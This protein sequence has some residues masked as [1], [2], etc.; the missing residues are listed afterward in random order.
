MAGSGT[1][2]GGAG[3]RDGYR[4]ATQRWLPGLSGHKKSKLKQELEAAPGALSRR[5][6]AARGGGTGIEWQRSD[7]STSSGLMSRRTLKLR[8]NDAAWG[9][10]RQTWVGNNPPASPVMNPLSVFLPFTD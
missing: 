7:S 10:A 8:I 3:R 5:Q 9:A 4:T 1:G 2:A 6:A